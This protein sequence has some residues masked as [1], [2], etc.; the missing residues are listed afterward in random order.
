MALSNFRRKGIET[1]AAEA[2]WT[3]ELLRGGEVVLTRHL[4]GLKKLVKLYLICDYCKSLHARICLLVVKYIFKEFKHEY[5]F[6]FQ[7]YLRYFLVD[8]I[9]KNFIH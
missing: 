6:I 1:V 8:T 7:L 5:Y 2:A 9:N 4:S 3:G